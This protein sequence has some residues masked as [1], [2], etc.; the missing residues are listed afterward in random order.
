MFSRRKGRGKLKKKRSKFF[1]GPHWLDKPDHFLE[2][3]ALN[4]CIANYLALPIC[5]GD[6]LHRLGQCL[7][8]RCMMRKNAVN[9]DI[10]DEVIWSRSTPS[11]DESRFG[12]RIESGINLHHI[13][14]L[15]I[16]W[17]SLNRRQFWRV[18]SFD[19]SRIGPTR[20]ADHYA[21]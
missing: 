4:L 2:H 6:V 15:R 20:G 9:L 8:R 16:P 21:F 18:P 5:A 19:K 14:E 13:K 17:Q 11:A 12:N 10:E 1:C 7:Y 3:G